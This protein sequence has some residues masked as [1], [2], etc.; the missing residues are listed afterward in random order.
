[1]PRHLLALPGL[2]MHVVSDPDL[3]HRAKHPTA[4]D[5]GKYLR[6]QPNCSQQLAVQAKPGNAGQCQLERLPL[7]SLAQHLRLTQTF[8]PA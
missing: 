5:T 6:L 3:A 8:P 4:T 2:G 7:R 1:M